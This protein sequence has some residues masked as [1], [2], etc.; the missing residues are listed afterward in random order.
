MNM[1]AV[2]IRWKV[3]RHNKMDL[4]KA[5]NTINISIQKEEHHQV[6]HREYC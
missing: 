3:V 1:Q 6:L 2:S 4:L 5:E